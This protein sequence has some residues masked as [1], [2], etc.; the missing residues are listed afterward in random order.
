VIRVSGTT[1]ELNEHGDFAWG[2]PRC[3]VWNKPTAGRCWACGAAP[4]PERWVADWKVPQE[5]A[6]LAAQMALGHR[7]SAPFA[8]VAV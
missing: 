2:C 8:V 5:A 7:V 6:V 3:A 4:I 1:V